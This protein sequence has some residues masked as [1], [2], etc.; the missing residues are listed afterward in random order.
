MEARVATPVLWLRA[1]FVGG[2]AFFLGAAGHLMADGLLPGPAFLVALAT[3]SVLVSVPVLSRPA[4]PLRLVALLVGGQTVIH[5]CLTLSA[6]HAGDPRTP[7][8]ARPRPEG[9]TSLPTVDGHRVG[10]FQD[11]FAGTSSLPSQT[12]TLPVHHL[13]AD[14]SAHAP[15]MVAHLLAAALVAV[16]IAVGERAAWTLVA[17]T[18]RRLAAL[19]RPV[20]PV[21]VA[22]GSRPSYAVDRVPARPRRPWVT[23]RLSRRGPPLLAS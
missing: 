16:W 13:V 8:A 17:L 7:A 5:L 15:M 1:L 2:F 19:V 3:F 22:V 21:T 6:G 12:P 14:L 20:L 10:S 9:L 23:R 18:T 4:T 11:A